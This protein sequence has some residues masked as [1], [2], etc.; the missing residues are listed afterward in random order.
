[1]KTMFGQ[2]REEKRKTRGR[3]Q[4]F[5]QEFLSRTNSLGIMSS[6]VNSYLLESGENAQELDVYENTI[7][8]VQIPKNRN[9][10]VKS[11]NGRVDRL[12]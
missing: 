1:M 7:L 12:L 8:L 11:G 10:F 5:S 3:N 6:F 4:W 9:L 2:R